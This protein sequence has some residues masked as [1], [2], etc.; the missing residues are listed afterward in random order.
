LTLNT[1]SDVILHH[2]R[3]KEEKDELLISLVIRVRIALDLFWIKIGFH[4]SLNNRKV[5]LPTN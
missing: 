2:F 4:T 1:L 5:H 3:N